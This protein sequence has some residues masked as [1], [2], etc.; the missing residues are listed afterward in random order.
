MSEFRLGPVSFEAAI[1]A[2]RKRRV[3]LPSEYYGQLQGEARSAAFTVSRLSQLAQIEEIRRSLEHDLKN[4]GD[5]ESWRRRVLATPR[6]AHL[7]PAHLE[8]VYRTNIQTHQASGRARSILEH[9]KTR[10]F[11]MYSAILDTRVRPEHAALHGIILPVDHPFWRSHIPPLGFNCRCQIISLSRRQAERRIAE[12]RARGK[13]IDVA[14]DG[15]FADEGWDY[16]RLHAPA[17]TGARRA[18]RSKAARVDPPVAQTIDTEQARQAALARAI[19]QA[20]QWVVEQG[21]PLVDQRIEFAV[22]LDRAGAQTFRVRGGAGYVNFTDA[23]LQSLR[24][25]YLIHNHPSNSSLSPADIGLAASWQL[26]EVIA[27]GSGGALYRARAV[28]TIQDVEAAIAKADGAV[29][30][31][32]WAQINAGLLSP[33]DAGFWHW[34]AVNSLLAAAGLVEY[35]ASALPA[36][37]TA[38]A[39]AISNLQGSFKP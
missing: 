7:T 32:F 21:R 6:F 3:V 13:I 12:A 38:V 27:A 23:E 35:S 22:G 37:P 1:K 25:G 2:A 9:A 10:P 31:E 36:M 19:E 20:Q 30:R 15:I 5:F 11:L 18:L 8:T 26:R 17:K 24:G 28:G 4:G 29:R 16:D 34:H 14:P 33:D 39:D